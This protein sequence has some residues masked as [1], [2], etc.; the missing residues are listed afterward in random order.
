MIEI[1]LVFGL[2]IV[3]GIVVIL[4]KMPVYWSLWILGHHIAF[5]I[6]V[7]VLVL[8][9]HWGTMTG[10]MAASVAGLCCSV[11]TSVGRRLFGYRIGTSY[12]VGKYDQT[13][14]IMQERARLR[15]G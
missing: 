3:A 8:L 1:V 9:I 10:L 5:D 13:L 6:G 2:L 11:I 4:A 15:R 14:A 12:Y 7:T